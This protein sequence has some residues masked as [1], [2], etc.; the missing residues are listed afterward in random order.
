MKK[1]NVFLCMTILL[2]TVACGKQTIKEISAETKTD[3]QTVL[4]ANQIETTGNF[5]ENF[6]ESTT[7]VKEAAKETNSVTQ[8]VSKKDTAEVPPYFFTID[9][10]ELREIKQAVE[11]MNETEFAE[12][13][14]KNFASEVRNGMDTLNKTKSILNELEETYIVVLDGKKENVSTLTFRSENNEIYQLVSFD[15]EHRISSYSYTPENTHQKSLKINEDSSVVKSQKIEHET[16]SAI[17]YELDNSDY[18]FL[19]GINTEDTFIVLRTNKIQSF[20][21]FKTY[22]ARLEFVK[23]GDLL[24]E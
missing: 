20:E 5:T 2:F 23:I 6:K 21:D 9:L 11:M 13:M 16:Y 15:E 19:A 1:I 18:T 7:K 10:N 24:N 8:A 17:L 22:F 4:N 14:N 3:L 12:Y